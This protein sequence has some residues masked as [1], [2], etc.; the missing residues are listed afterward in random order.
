MSDT[1]VDFKVNYSNNLANSINKQF[2]II[3]FFMKEYKS[4]CRPISANRCE[5]TCPICNDETMLCKQKECTLCCR[6]CATVGDFIAII[7]RK[8][9]L[10]SVDT[11]QYMVNW[12]LKHNYAV[13][14]KADDIESD[15][16]L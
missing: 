9:N 10:N 15:E 4:G 2:P 11:L 6:N 12:M 14:I 3:S 16:S 5:F 1:F 8:E 7:A 13:R